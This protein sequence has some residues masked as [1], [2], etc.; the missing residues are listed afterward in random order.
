MNTLNPKTFP[1]ADKELTIQILNLIEL[2]KNNNQL[3]KG[4]NE[5]VKIINKGFAELIII[6]ADSDPIEIVLHLPLLCEDKNIPYVFINNKQ[7]LGKACGISRSVI[8][9]CIPTN[10]N[11]NLNEQIKNIKNKIEKFLN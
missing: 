3:K 5:T 9:C 11:S 2:S 4:A 10:L 1:F 8:A 6:A 7:T